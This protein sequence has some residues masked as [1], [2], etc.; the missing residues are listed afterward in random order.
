MLG[1]RAFRVF[2]SSTFRD[3]KSERDALQEKV[4]PQLRAYCAEKGCAFQAVDLRWGIREEASAGHR[5]MRICLSEVARCQEVSPR[6]NFVVQLGDRYGWRPLPEVINAKEFETLKDLLAPED[7]TAAE[8]AYYRDENAVPPEYVLAPAREGEA[9]YDADALREALA[10][11]ARRAGLP[12]AALAKY[13]LSAT[14][15]E[16]LKG[17][18]EAEHADEHVFCFLRELSGLPD[19]VPPLPADRELWP[20]AADYRDFHADG[21]PDKEGGELLKDLKSRLRQ[22]LGDNSSRRDRGL[23]DNAFDYQAEWT[24]AG[25]STAHIDR[26]CEDMLSSLTRVIDAEIERLGA[27]SHLDQERAAHS[28]F[29]EEHADGFIGRVRYLDA[30]A[31]YLD[32]GEDNPLCVFAAGGL[33]KSALIARATTDAGEK[34]SDAVIVTRFIGVTGSSADPRSLLQDLCSEIGEAYG[35]TDPVPSTLQDLQQEL[36]KRLALA[37]AERPLI[38]FLD[39]LDQLSGSEG[40]NLSWLPSDLPGGVRLVTTT[41]PGPS[42]DGLASRLPENLVLEL[43]RMPPDEGETLLRSWLRNSGRTLRPPQRKEIL[44]HF[45]T[46]GSP[47]YLRLAFEEARLWPSTLKNVRIGADEQSIIGELYDRLEAEH[48]PELV[49]HALGFLA[50]TYERLGLSEDELLDALTADE[51]TWTEFTRAEWEMPIRQMPVVVWSRLYFDLAPYLSPRASEGASLLTFFHK[52]LAD[53][54][55]HRYV[56]GQSA[57]MHDVLAGVMQALARGKDAGA[58]EWRGSAHALAELPY[59]LTRAE[60]W[61]DLFATLTDFTYLEQ[62]AQRVAVVT[63]APADADS[64][65]YNGVLALINDYDRALAALPTEQPPVSNLATARSDQRLVLEAFGKVLRRE[66]HN[67]TRLPD[68]L[69]QQTYNRLQWLDGPE[70]GGVITEVLKPELEE[71]SKPGAGLWLHSLTR[72][73][74]SGALIRDLAGHTGVVNAVA[75]SPDGTRIVSGAGTPPFGM[76]DNTLKVWDAGTGAEL[77]TLTGHTGLVNAVAYSPDGTRIVSGS[78][79]NDLKIWDAA[80][81]AELLTLTGHTDSVHAVSY[82]PDGTRIGSASHDKTLKVWDAATGAELL[83]LT[84]H[85][86]PVFAVAFSPDGTRM[87]SGSHDHPVKVWDA[88]SG[89]GLV[90]LAGHT[91]PVHAVAYSPDGSRIVSGSWDNTLKVWDAAT[92]AELATLTGHT[93]PVHAV[94]YSPDGTRIASGSDDY[95]VRVWDAASGAGLATFS[96]HT[97]TVNAVAFSPDG[98]RIVSGSKGIVKVWDAASDAEPTTLTGHTDW[99]RAVA[100]APDGARIASGSRDGI[101]KVWDA[102]TGAELAT[103]NYA[104]PVEAMAYSP[105]GTRIV[106]GGLDKT[107][108]VWDAATGVK[109]AT[110]AGHTEFVDAVAYSPDGT[111][112][113]SGSADH[114]LKVWDTATSAELTTLTGHTRT[115]RAVAYSPDGTR[116]A[117]GSD[118]A[119]LKVWDAATG[120]ELATVHPHTSSVWEAAHGLSGSAVRAV[121]YSPDGTRVLSGAGD[122]GL[123]VWDAAGGAPLAG[124][125]HTGSLGSFA[126]SPDGTRIVFGSG[127]DNTVKVWDCQKMGCVAV[128]PCIGTPSCCDYSPQGT[129]VCSGDLSGTVYILELMGES[130]HH[131]PEARPFEP[132]RTPQL[133][134]DET[135]EAVNPSTTI[136]YDRLEAEHGPELVGHALGFLACTYERLGLS[137]DELLDALAADEETWAEFTAGAEWEM[138]VR[139]L[140]VVVWSR[141]YFDLAPYLSPRA[142]GGTSLLSFF[143]KE[144]ADAAQHR[145]VDG[146]AAQMHDVLAGVMQA[147]AR[148]KDAGPREWRGSTH[149]LAEL[150]YHLTRAERWDD[151]FATLTDF[152]YLEQKA[153]RVAVATSVG[154]DGEDVSVYNGVL[155]LIDDYDRALAAFPTDQPLVD[156]PTMARPDQR[157]VLKEFG[158]VLAREAH[159]LTRRPDLLWQQMYNRLQWVEWAEKDGVLT[160]VLEPELEERGKPGAGLWLHSLTRL[161]ESQALIRVLAGHTDSVSSVAFSPDGSRIVSGSHDNTL[162]VWDAASGAELATLTG[163]WSWVR[164]VAF[165][166][167]GRRIVSGSGDKTLKVWDAATGVELATLTGH[168]DW[169][170]AVAFSPD[171]SRIVSAAG[172]RRPLGEEPGD[173]TLK[174]WDAASGAELATFTGHTSQVNAVA[175]SPDGSR[176]VSGSDDK[177]IKVWDAV[178]GAELATLAGHTGFVQSV[179]YSPDGS[180]IVSGSTDKTVK[181][182]D[183]AGGA[184][185]ATLS[186]HAELVWAVA[187]SLDGRRIVSGSADHTLKVWDAVSGAELA[188][189]SG[190]TNWVTAVAFSLDGRRIVSGSADHTLKVWDAAWGAELATLTGHTSRVHA[191]ACSPDGTRIVSGSADHTLKVW[192]AASGAELATL[193]GHRSFVYDV[194]YSPDGSRIVSGAWDNTL[195]VWD[196]A[197]GAELA[198]LT[199]HTS[200]VNAVAYSPDGSRIVSGSWDGTIKVWDAASGAIL[201]TLTGHTNYVEAVA[202]SPDGTRIVT[203]SNDKTIKIWDAASGAELAT[204]TDYTCGVNAVAYSPDG[205][206]IVSGSEDNTVRIWDARRMECVAM[207]PCLGPV[208]CC[209]YSPQWTRICCGDTSGTVYILELMGESPRHWLEARQFEPRRTPELSTDN[210]PEAVNRSTTTVATPGR[211]HWWSRR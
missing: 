73:R 34:H 58:R 133:S 27:V 127:S 130:S 37:S 85:T 193:T 142:S 163:H 91:G 75:Y 49:G 185:L 90:T 208:S 168:T 80:T 12:G 137:E 186:G 29:A 54:A 43:D 63:S 166:P 183:A 171:G 189:L 74:E 97:Y 124:L 211:R 26:L 144:L 156:G 51:Q 161:R 96:G 40:T 128:L 107:L 157:L 77:A 121:A 136:L 196:A 5:T 158:K 177:T 110:L 7:S 52:E 102:A 201:A 116:I 210:T 28:T 92:G 76:T 206:R 60:R 150:P 114:T 42:L 178:G 23:G 143:H 103:L 198:T 46:C 2:V 207:L 197:S 89:A 56:D 68:L 14:E 45:K 167:D 4:F 169:V 35:S 109:L 155:A 181:V 86:E 148:G 190:D 184:E 188:T 94:A 119:T 115:V 48:G 204:L 8:A 99:V 202:Y 13:M 24:G 64:G 19:R 30:I 203:C 1:T 50:C 135:P 39:S 100:Y 159:T 194:A 20:P 47:L 176:I 33:G 112:I 21:T 152:T 153:K 118:D 17:A 113:V 62:M 3:L 66:A 9:S 16:I 154:A 59:H 78:G 38:V 122:E 172:L 145:Y 44:K 173:T 126:C 147:L 182:W 132:R 36:P 117:S 165:S 88:A 31:R 187:F 151:L 164:A 61:D 15:Q 82:S 105:D 200:Y 146:R 160:G 101:L 81:G 209:D 11:A 98:R 180:R 83:T 129:H 195:K 53:A 70:K 72:A 191:V 25:P 139:R 125:G 134:T 131:R 175:Y 41:R 93:K 65:V 140:P 55:Q 6:P 174:V 205:S 123:K 67:L 95:T 69:W 18:F 141:L 111:R 22:R 162:K 79:D 10:E 71:R 106:S 192:D 138:P 32:G 149:A 57:Q 170:Q 84:G 199:G 108:K 120:A 104:G 179:A 87:V